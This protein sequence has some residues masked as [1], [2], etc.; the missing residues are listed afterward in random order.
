[1]VKISTA[2]N[3]NRQGNPACK[4]YILIIIDLVIMIHQWH[5]STAVNKRN[6]LNSFQLII[7][8]QW[9]TCQLLANDVSPVTEEKSIL[10]NQRV[11]GRVHYASLVTSSRGKGDICIVLYC[12]SSLLS[13]SL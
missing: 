4:Y 3:S 10:L 13:E 7:T 11:C 1:M 6:S 9:P 12:K 5:N 8:G 2:C